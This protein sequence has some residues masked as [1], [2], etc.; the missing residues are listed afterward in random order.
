[1]KLT[2]V[3]EVGSLDK[4]SGVVRAAAGVVAAQTAHVGAQAHHLAVL[5]LHRL[6]DACEAATLQT[7]CFSSFLLHSLPFFMD[8][9]SNFVWLSRKVGHFRSPRCLSFV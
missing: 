9:A 5:V 3:R 1:M 4:W 7:E 6:V 8:R 2:E